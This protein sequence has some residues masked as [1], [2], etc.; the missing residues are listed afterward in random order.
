MTAVSELVAHETN[1]SPL[2]AG[3]DV[4]INVKMREVDLHVS[5]NL[6]LW[7]RRLKQKARTS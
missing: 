6:K 7:L 2:D 3:L 5:L 4:K 1:Q